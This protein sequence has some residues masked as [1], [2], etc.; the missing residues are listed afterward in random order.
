MADEFTKTFSSV[1]EEIEYWKTLC[2]KYK[3]RL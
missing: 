2:K 1:H 3:E